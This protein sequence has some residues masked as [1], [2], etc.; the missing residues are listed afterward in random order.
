MSIIRLAVAAAAAAASLA[1]SACGSDDMSGMTHGSDMPSVDHSMHPSD[2]AGAASA[3]AVD[4]VLEMNVEGGVVTPGPRT[5][6]VAV[7]STIALKVTSDIADEVH[8]HG[9]DAHLDLTADKPGTLTLDL[10]IPGRFE[11]E[12][13]EAGTQLAELEVS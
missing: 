8:V 5:V 2:P 6:K 13:E 9:Y 12:L 4:K 1:L 7:G 11:V 3:S 10:D